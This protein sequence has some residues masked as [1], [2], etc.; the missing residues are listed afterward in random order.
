MIRCLKDQL[1]DGAEIHYLVKKKFYDCIKAHPQVE[2]FH[3]F[4]NNPEEV[5]HGLR[6]EN[7]DYILDL[8]NNPRSFLIKRKLN[9]LSFTVNKINFQK[10]LMVNL[11]WN[12]LPEVHIVDRYLETL[13]PFGIV[14]DGKGLDYFIPSEDEINLHTLPATHQNGYIAFVIGGNYITKKLPHEKIVAACSI[15][16]QPI[17]L[18]GGTEDETTGKLIISKLNADITPLVL[19]SCGKY[20]FNQSASLVKQAKK[21]ITHDTGLMH[22]AAAFKK[23]IVSVWGNTIPEFGMVPYYGK[24]EIRNWKLEITGLACRPCSKLGFEK[25]PRG[26]F[27][28]MRMQ[29]EK[30]ISTAALS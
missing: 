11:K 29:D 12:L 30:A 10:W 23:E 21:V 5:I 19:N 1:E 25:C 2:K 15:I 8:H 28:C 18:L 26:H 9:K 17:I 14:N 24:N 13:K 22:I 27:K 3:L 16:K 4:D 6:D 20:N 7:F